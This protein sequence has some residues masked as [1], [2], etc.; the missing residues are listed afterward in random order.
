MGLGEQI[1]IR[2]EALGLSREGL[3]AIADVSYATIIRVEG[4]A[5]VPQRS[6]LAAI[7]RALDKAEKEKAEA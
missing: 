2:R 5:G 6:T 3:A 7:Q 4:D 1:Q